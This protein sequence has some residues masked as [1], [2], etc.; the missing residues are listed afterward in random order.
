MTPARLPAPRPGGR[1]L[2]GPR[3]P[4]TTPRSSAGPAR[5]PGRGV[6]GP[7]RPALVRRRRPVLVPQRPARAGPR[8]SSWSMPRRGREARRSTTPSWPPGC[9][10]RPGNE[11]RADRLPFD[12]IEFADDGKA[13]RFEAAGKAWTCDLD[14]LRVRRR[15]PG[16][17]EAAGRRRPGPAA[18]ELG[19]PDAAVP[20]NSSPTRAAGRPTATARSPSPDGKWVAFV[21]DHNVFLRPTDGG[22]AVQ[23]SKAGDRGERLRHALLVAGRQGAGRLPDRAG[24][25]QGG[26]PGRVVAP[27]RRPGEAHEPAL[28]RCRATSS[29]PTSRGCST[30]RARRRRRSRPT[31]ST[32]AGRGCGGRKDGRHFTY[33]KVDRGH[34]RFRLVE[35]DAHTGKTRNLIDEKTDTFIWTAHTENVSVP[36]VTWLEKTDEIIYASEKDGWRH[37][38]LIDAKTGAVEEPDHARASGS[39]AASTG[40][41]RRSGRSGSG[42]AARTRTRTRTSSTTTASTSTAPGLV[43]LTEG[44]GTHTVQFSPE[45]QV[46]RSTPISRVDL[47]PVHELRRCDDGKLVCKLEEA[48]V[49][50]LKASGWEPPEV[51]VA[52]GRDGEDRHLG[53]HRPAAELRPGEEVPGDREHLRRA[54]GLVRAEG[55]QRRS[56]GSRTLTDLGFIVVQIDGMGTANR[57]KAFHDVCWKNLKDAG[58]PD[59]ILWHKAVGGEVPVVRHHPRRH[60]RRLGRRAERDAAAVLFHGDF[61]KAAVAGVR[62]PRQPDGQGEL[63][64]AVDG[65]PGRPALRRVA[66][67]S[68]TPTGCAASCC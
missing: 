35:V 21:K 54:A 43:A 28:R 7:D 15:R 19:R 68:T 25:G 66:R 6:Q 18:D 32:S 20:A 52:K 26:P 23:L 40:S 59:R 63:E 37:L 2:A 10:R 56:A 29:P 8:S 22:E 33:E 27:G 58:F 12:E 11:Y 67:T 30:W 4:P 41:T 42:P 44:N 16:D 55:V 38:Y 31:G 47:P 1:R 17:G 24:G 53:R 65:L 57:S 9:R 36:L 64:R 39:S 50:E 34:Q 5:P 49:A 13:V 3:R 46:P 48:D 61:Y 14:Y 60:L 51:F 62:L 45:P